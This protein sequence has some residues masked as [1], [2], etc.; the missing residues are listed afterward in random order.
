MLMKNFKRQCMMAL[1]SLIVSAPLFAEEVSN[2]T[3]DFN[4]KI[5]VSDHAFKVAPCWKHIVGKYTDEWGDTY[6]MN[7]SYSSTSGRSGGSLY[8]PK[9]EA[10]DNYDTNP[11]SDYLVT[12]VVSGDVTIYVKARSTVSAAEV[13]AV[14]DDGSVGSRIIR[15]AGN[16]STNKLSTS[17][18]TA[19]TVH[20]EDPQRI[21][22]KMHYVD[23][24]DF[25][26]QTAVI[27]PEPGMKI[28]S[29]EPSA[30]TGVLYWDQLPD[31]SVE[32]KFMVTVTN[33]GQT[34]LV[35]G[36]SKYS[37]SIINGTNNQVYGTTPVPVDLA[38]G[39]T[40]EPFEVVMKVTDPKSVWSYS[41][42]Q[43]KLYLRENITGTI[44]ARA[45]SY[46][47]E[48]KSKFVFRK[49]GASSSSNLS[50]EQAF[51]MISKPTT[52][53]YEIYND[54][55]APL[56]VK[57]IT[58]PTG[59]TTDVADGE[60]TV[61]KKTSKAVNITVDCTTTGS[62]SGNL[63]VLYD[64]NG[65][66]K[67]YTL[68]LSAVVIKEGTWVADFNNT[69]ST[70]RWPV[71]SVAEAGISSG[72][73]YQA[74]QYDNWLTSY[75]SSE[76]ATDNNKFI[77]PKLH[78]E[79]G[80]S[81]TFDAAYDA[82]GSNYGMKVYISTDRKNWG[83]PIAEFPA[84]ELK[85]TFEKKSI[86]IA[87]A[88]DYYV[89]FALWRVKLDNIAGFKEVKGID[90]DV[91][92]TNLSVS[93][94]VQSGKTVLPTVTIIPVKEMQ[95][96][97]YAVKFY[98]NGEV[99]ATA[100]SKD[101]AANAKNTQTFKFTEWTPEVAATTD[102]ETYAQVEF[103]DGSVFKSPVKILKV[104][105]E[106]E[107]VFFNKGTS[108]GN[109]KPENLKTPI[110]FGKTNELGAAK[111][112]EVYNFGMAPLTVKSVSVPE[113]FSVNATG[114]FTVPSKERKEIVL[115]FSAQT[116]GVYEG[117]MKIV[118][119]DADGTDS[120]YKINVSGTL[121]DPS[122]WY[123]SFGTAKDAGTW[124]KGS[125]HESKFGL[126]NGGTVTDPNWYATSSSSTDNMMITPKLHASEGEKLS[127][128][129]RIYSSGWPEGII[130]IFA[131]ATRDGLKDEANRVKVGSFC[132]KNTD[133]TKMTATWQTFNVAMPGEGDWYLGFTI[134][135]RAQLDELYG[136]SL[137]DVAH[138]WMLE[139]A[140]VPE[141]GM[142]NV[143][144]TAKLK[145][146]NVGLRDEKAGE[147]T[148]TAYVDGKPM[149]K[150][151]DTDMV[152]MN[153][154]TDDATEVTIPFRS[155]KVGT[156]PVYFEV[157]AGDYKVA[158]EPVNMV[159]SE[160]QLVS[161]VTVGTPD[162]CDNTKF[163]YFFDKNSTG[164]VLYNA[165]YLG[166]N[167]GD[168]INRIAFKGY[169][170]DNIEENFQL[171]YE[172][173]DDQTQTKPV[174]G[175]YATGKMITLLDLKNHQ[176][177]KSGT[178][179]EPVE[180]IT[181]ELDEPIV[182]QAGKS[183]RF[184]SRSS[185]TAYKRTNLLLSTTSGNNYGH[186]HDKP[187]T[188][189]T[190]SW[191]NTSKLPMLYLGLE[192]TPI[193]LSGT[194]SNVDDTPAE[195]AV[196]TLVSTDGDDIQYSATTDAA[197]KY[198]VNVVQSN[199]TYNV[200]A[201]KENLL[202]YAD[203]ITFEDNITLDFMLM[204]QQT[205]SYDEPSFIPGE[206]NIL[207]VNLSFP[208]GINT[209]CLPFSMSYEEAMD[210]LGEGTE[211]FILKSDN[212]AMPRPVLSFEK[213]ESYIEA[214]VPYM[215]I[216]PEAASNRFLAKDRGL[217][218]APTDVATQSVVFKGTFAAVELGEG[219]K[220][221]DG[222]TMDEAA[223]APTKAPAKAEA[224]K[225]NPFHA[226]L[227]AKPGLTLEDVAIMTNT[228]V[229]VGIEEVAAEEVGDAV[230]YNLQGIRVVNPGTGL[231]IING[232]K[233]YLKR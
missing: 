65:T 99:K 56:L 229:T 37:V 181:V 59:F 194:V 60:F 189:A 136:L 201:E 13:L 35:K 23:I 78:A 195:G 88:G 176:F 164:V 142:Q 149:E 101:F 209:I 53:N 204:R 33:T 91:Y 45:P 98:A 51:G 227:E 62:F 44:V 182:Y 199:R 186:S 127:F 208:A 213:Y 90:N 57:S 11:V 134:N 217:I 144:H 203:G 39:A 28:E 38:M 34:N 49:G 105:N 79:A 228:G 89:G 214:G 166:L 10:G 1:A 153:N 24:D 31:G 119:V 46:Y 135:G 168:K 191:D 230:I 123:V 100:E 132:G 147:Y 4:T 20:L 211:L 36:Q 86:T 85:S 113:G 40:S 52:L 41:S 137:V 117:E 58:L 103:T 32:V 148:L 15:Y 125:L 160:E 69:T 221:L 169:I 188:F 231:Y 121:L 207:D 12:P 198:T 172:L 72:N 206:H 108:V 66:D 157:K 224:K 71:G 17:D 84:S 143:L 50:G 42:A 219:M 205:I 138:D 27:E 155:S 75:T 183:L 109:Y 107:F 218:E 156:Y 80:E 16:S 96:A 95:A 114:E 19:V 102:F 26:A 200:K 180:V 61:D 118:Y 73:K 76:F 43:A 175:E 5:D 83:E 162:K 179:N 171:Y 223:A 159:F 25:S 177:K 173:T 70:P 220:S 202:D 130:E 190:Q 67:T 174:S 170:A 184:V 9:Q 54:G 18:W 215:A 152:V 6:Y 133:E 140:N 216:L 122:K 63:E 178:V 48:Y 232:K 187:E 2:Y 196:V 124:P 129:G 151:A 7:Y 81:M 74:P 193:S 94:M 185:A 225:V 29:A 197:G 141:S 8:C 104:T 112:F 131:A 47:R 222:M 126:A 128:D 82:S 212:G 111:E 145:L 163:M 192:V 64:D 116:A 154:L 22:Y 87:E 233:V 210:M 115:T 30:T 55:V 158:T 120:E 110:A 139:S 14:N 165:E 21:A 92:F 146:R 97:N 167:D 150:V 161:D 226:Y 106:P 3:V 93:E 77:T 68:P